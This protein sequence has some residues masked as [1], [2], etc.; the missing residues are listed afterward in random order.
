MLWRCKVSYWVLWVKHKNEVYRCELCISVCFT[1]SRFWLRS[2]GAVSSFTVSASYDTPGANSHP[3]IISIAQ[4][5]CDQY[6]SSHFP[7]APLLGTRLWE[8]SKVQGGE[9]HHRTRPHDQGQRL[10]M[11][12]RRV[13]VDDG[14]MVNAWVDDW[15]WFAI[16]LL[17]LKP[18]HLLLTHTH[19]VP[20][21]PPGLVSGG[22]AAPGW[23][24]CVCR[25]AR[26][27]A[28]VRPATGGSTLRNMN[29]YTRCTDI[30]AHT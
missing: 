9:V 29:A 6:L 24:L 10:G 25:R 16:T 2:H 30:H 27:R 12:R 1:S 7:L 15:L 21:C 5:F 22:R 19:L 18:L 11:N 26:A 4:M 8:Q 28:C 13:E 23:S 17:N 20:G 3:L 14:W